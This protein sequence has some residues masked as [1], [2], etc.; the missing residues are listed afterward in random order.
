[1]QGIISTSILN[2]SREYS[3]IPKLDIIHLSVPAYWKIKPVSHGPSNNKVVDNA[4]AKGRKKKDVI[5]DYEDADT[6]NLLKQFQLGTRTKYL[7]GT[8]DTWQA[9]DNHIYYEDP[10]FDPKS[11]F[12]LEE[13]PVVYSHVKYQPAERGDH[14][15]PPKKED[16]VTENCDIDYHA[17]D[18]FHDDDDNEADMNNDVQNESMPPVAESMDHQDVECSQTQVPLTGSNLI[19]AP[20]YTQEMNI[21]YSKKEKKLDIR[22]FK[23]AMRSIIGKETAGDVE[24]LFSKIYNVLPTKLS[25]SNIAARSVPIAF[26]SLLH[27]A[28]EQTLHLSTIPNK[29]DIIVKRDFKSWAL[30]FLHLR[31]K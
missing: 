17:R 22:Q 25:K 7:D 12:C 10:N 20:E 15:D 13:K 6:E 16:V 1:M 9:E 5:L 23:G 14:Q 30:S 31:I 18:D 29:S 19:Q 11:M 27:I 2:N 4:A 8:L 28:N 3:Y 21:P 24:T 26:V